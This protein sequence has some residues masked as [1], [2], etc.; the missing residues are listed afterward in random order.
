M[1][2]LG[3][4]IH[5]GAAAG[6]SPVTRLEA[7]LAGKRPFKPVRVL[8]HGVPH[9]AVMT[10][11]GS[12]RSLDIEGEVARAMDK[13]GLEQNVLTQGKFELE[14]AWRTLAEAVL[15]SEQNPV[16]FGTA[17]QW[18]R[19]VPEVVGDLWIQYAELRAEHDPQVAELT[20]DEVRGIRDAVAK[21]NAPALRYFGAS[22]L[23]RFLLS[24]ADLL[25]SSWTER[26][27]PG[28]SSPAI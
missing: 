21:K 28:G 27:S 9:E 1:T 8:V 13:R 25:A 26:S 22:R 23:S 19:L 10:V 20:E 14:F 16:P 6:K 17:E 4:A 24:S 18:G 11:I 2:K 5:K 15:D 7:A 3:D 12:E